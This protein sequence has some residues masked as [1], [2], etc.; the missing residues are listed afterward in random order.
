MVTVGRDS[1]RTRVLGAESPERDPHLPG[2]G[3]DKTVQSVQ[4]VQS[5]T[6]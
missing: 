2:Y 4:S 3:K 6:V 5:M 1:K